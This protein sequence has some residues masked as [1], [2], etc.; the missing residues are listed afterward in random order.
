VNAVGAPDTEGFLV[1]DGE[2]AEGLPEALQTR[3][4]EIGGRDQLEGLRG[5]HHVGGGHADVHV[6]GICAD[7]FLE[8]GQKRDEVVPRGGLDLVDA[9]GGHAGRGLDA[10]QRLRGD[11]AALGVDLAYRE[12][13]LEPRLVPGVLGPQ[14][15]HL[16]PRISGDHL[17]STCLWAC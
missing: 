17:T 15:G 16:R 7:R 4:E 3:E 12:L 6:A 14:P 11:E 10:A 1:A 8:V 9:G 13:D 2:T 5:V